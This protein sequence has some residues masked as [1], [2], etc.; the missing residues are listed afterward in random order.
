MVSEMLSREWRTT[1]HSKDWPADVVSDCHSLE[2]QGWQG[3]F[4]IPANR[5]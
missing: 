1:A 5:V 4:A 2:L 3:A